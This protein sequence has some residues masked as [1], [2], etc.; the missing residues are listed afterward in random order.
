MLTSS[1]PRKVSKHLI[2]PLEVP[3]WLHDFDF[4]EELSGITPYSDMPV[5]SFREQA[6]LKLFLSV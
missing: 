5:L 1:F 4:N 3:I 6:S 2:M